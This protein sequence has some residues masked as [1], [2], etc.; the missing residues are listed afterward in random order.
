[1][2]LTPNQQRP[3]VARQLAD[4]TG[5]FACL[6]FVFFCLFID[7]FLRVYLNIYHASDW[8]TCIICPHSLINHAIETSTAAGGIRET[9][10]CPFRDLSSPRV[11]VSASC[12]VTRPSTDGDGSRESAERENDGPR[13]VVT[14]NAGRYCLKCY[15]F[16]R[17]RQTFI[18]L[19]QMRHAG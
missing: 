3:R 7:V 16:C 19:R 11:G 15:C 17:R 14:C 5:D 13:P 2:F 18:S 6:V 1:M 12:P 4:A 9:A 10:S 8:V